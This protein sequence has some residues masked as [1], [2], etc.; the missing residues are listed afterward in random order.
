MA[1]ISCLPTRLLFFLDADQF[2]NQA[3]ATALASSLQSPL[4]I[5][6]HRPDAG[7]HAQEGDHPGEPSEAIRPRDEPRPISTRKAE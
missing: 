2:C 5:P 7:E 1:T 6:F 4:Q 3:V